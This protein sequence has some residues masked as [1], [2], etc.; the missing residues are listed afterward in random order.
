MLLCAREWDMR[1][2]WPRDADNGVVEPWPQRW[3]AGWRKWARWFSLRRF[4]W[5]G[6]LVGAGLVGLACDDQIHDHLQVVDAV[7][8]LAVQVA[9]AQSVA[10]APAPDKPEL[11][12]N[13]AQ[14]L[15]GQQTVTRVWPDLQQALTRHGLRVTSMRP[16][17][18]PVTDLTAMPWPS[19]AVAVRMTG[20][21]VDWQKAWTDLSAAGPVWSMDHLSVTPHNLSAMAGAGSQAGAAGVQ[22]DAVLRVWLQ[23]GPD[24]PNAWPMTRATGASV[25]AQNRDEVFGLALGTESNVPKDLAAAAGPM[26]QVSGSLAALPADPLQWPLARVRLA[27]LWQQEGQWQAV[28]AAGP[29]VVPVRTGQRIAQ[30]GWRIEAVQSASVRLRSAQGALHELHL[31]GASP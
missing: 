13:R 16:L 11:A 8:R 31:E 5:F 19:Q 23:P 9:S 7:D 21:F 4:V 14:T 20:R 30:G 15:P 25:V 18:E 17:S 28:L 27:G 29:H 24:G 22:V 12:A 26:P 2:H 3:Q 1:L 6:A 10:T